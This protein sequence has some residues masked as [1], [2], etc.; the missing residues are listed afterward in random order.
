MSGV[1]TAIG[2]IL[3]VAG[4]FLAFISVFTYTA[5]YLLLSLFFVF[6]ILG[7]LALGALNSRKA[8]TNTSYYREYVAYA[9]IFFALILAMGLYLFLFGLPGIEKKM[10]GDSVTRETVLVIA[11]V[12]GLLTYFGIGL[13]MANIV[14]E[15]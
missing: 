15:E 1:G 13:I 9:S 14:A 12:S 8:K 10:T 3:F 11:I 7:G 2:G 4:G 5:N 6:G